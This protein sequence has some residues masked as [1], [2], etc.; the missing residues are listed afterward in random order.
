MP[1]ITI[2]PLEKHPSAEGWK[3]WGYQV[4][5]ARLNKSKEEEYQVIYQVRA[6][7]RS[8]G[9]TYFILEEK[10]GATLTD[11]WKTV[12]IEK[13]KKSTDRKMLFRARKY[14]RKTLESLVPEFEDL[15]KVKK[16]QGGKK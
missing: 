7:T 4:S 11:L 14:A 8:E 5:Y 1:K 16:K 2:K 3:G 9:G 6:R 15:S 13:K 10:F 12:G